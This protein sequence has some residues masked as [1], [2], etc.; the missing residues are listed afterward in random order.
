MG[1]NLFRARVSNIWPSDWIQPVGQAVDQD[2]ALAP[3]PYTDRRLQATRGWL[4]HHTQLMPWT[5]RAMYSTGSNPCTIGS[6]CPVLAP[7]IA[8]TTS[9]GPSMRYPW[10]AKLDRSCAL[11]MGPAHGT[12]C[13][14]HMGW[15]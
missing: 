1:I 15:T 4:G 2:H 9:P 10:H 6:V 7:R 5:P 12:G 3:A 11:H 8:C 14:Q 13:L